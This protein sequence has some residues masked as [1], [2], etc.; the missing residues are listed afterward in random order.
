MDRCQRPAPSDRVVVVMGATTTEEL[1][2]SP[3][4]TDPTKFADEFPARRPPFPAVA[5]RLL[6][7]REEAE[8]VAQESCTRACAVGAPG[9]PG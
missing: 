9:P 1:D 3:E 5:Y 4:P 7:D 2:L 6:G 8:D